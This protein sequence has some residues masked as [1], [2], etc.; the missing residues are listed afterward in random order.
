MEGVLSLEEQNKL[1][2]IYQTEQGVYNKLK[3]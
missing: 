1:Y 2:N 3:K